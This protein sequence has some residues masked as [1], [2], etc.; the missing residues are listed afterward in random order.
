MHYQR[1][2]LLYVQ[3]PNPST[4]QGHQQQPIRLILR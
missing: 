2:F 4:E 1:L 3:A